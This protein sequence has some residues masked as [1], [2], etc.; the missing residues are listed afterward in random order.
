MRTVGSL[1]VMLAATVMLAIPLSVHAAD[2][3]ALRMAYM[4]GDVQVNNE[5]TGEWAPASANMPL[6][7]GDRLW[8]PSNARAEI[9]SRSGN[10]IRLDHET[11][12]D[13]L[14]IEDHSS[15]IYINSGSAYISY[16]GADDLM[17]VDSP[18]ASLRIKNKSKLNVDVA[19]N[20]ETN[21]LVF[22]GRVL[23]ED[24]AG[25][26]TIKTGD[27]LVLKRD[28]YARVYDMPVANE[29]DR[30]NLTRDKLYSSVPASSRYLPAELQSYS[31]DLNDNGRWT[32]VRDYGWVWT[33]S[34]VVASGWAPYRMGRWVWIGGDYTWVS[35]EPW[36][37]A[38]YH[39]GRWAYTPAAGWFWVPP[40][41]GYVYW[42][43]GYVGWV[44]TS[45]Y[46]S[47]VPLA[48]GEIYYG[49]GYFGP[50]S[51]NVT[52]VTV[53]KTVV[54]VYRNVNVNNAVTVVD[55][56]SFMSGHYRQGTFDRNRYLN[57]KI[58]VAGPN[59]S[60]TRESRMPSLRTV[61]S[62]RMPPAALNRINV[63][64]N[65]EERKL[66]RAENISV[67]HPGA[68]PLQGRAETVSK[69]LDRRNPGTVDRSEQ[70]ITNAPPPDRSIK[71]QQ[72]GTTVKEPTRQ[73][74]DDRIDRRIAPD[75][76]K[77][78]NTNSRKPVD[79]RN[80]RPTRPDSA[81]QKRDLPGE[82]AGKPEIKQQPGSSGRSG[83]VSRPESA[84]AA[85]EKKIDRHAD[86]PR[87]QNQDI[88]NKRRL[89]DRSQQM[90]QRDEKSQ[91]E[92]R[93]ELKGHSPSHE[94]DPRMQ[95]KE[96]AEPVRQQAVQPQAQPQPKHEKHDQNGKPEN[97]TKK[98]RPDNIKEEGDN[99]RPW[100]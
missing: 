9:Q 14:R 76:R 44:R 2:F 19:E 41:K 98:E 15:Q 6:R 32:E 63:Q 47:W 75:E 49:R 37:W 46:V 73:M 77:F 33:P 27:A 60:P 97:D 17:Q 4:D 34:V 42:G 62:D 57:E 82:N 78:D 70:R 56:K 72:E 59:I 91:P 88:I 54:N 100:K 53:N 71:H 58:S 85:A 68:K 79:D 51:V 67:M 84:P 13:I 95:P 12:A 3:G 1:F 31:R 87:P 40:R 21:V 10:I 64:H 20:S 16:S 92:S 80:V 36:G 99:H 7:P 69:P 29:W 74:R 23:A 55:H 39:Y 35:D 8:V 61:H 38:P 25:V 22:S 45:T 11:S 24:R 86:A 30:W 83:T 26:V 90:R 50:H 18:I 81:P 94:A 52:N 66:G 96:H 43:P 48:P 28:Q 5:D 89:D 65:R 93:T